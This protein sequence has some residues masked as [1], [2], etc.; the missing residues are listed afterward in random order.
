MKKI[1]ATDPI[2]Y[3]TKGLS[4]LSSNLWCL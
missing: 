1:H 3:G 2:K 4:L